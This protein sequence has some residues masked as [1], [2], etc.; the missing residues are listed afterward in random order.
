MSMGEKKLISHNDLPLWANDNE[1]IVSG[2][3]APGGVNE[4]IRLKRRGNHGHAAEKTMKTPRKRKSQSAISAKTINEPE[5]Y[6]H[7][8]FYRCW[9]SIWLYIHNESVNIHTHFWGALVAISA[10]ALHIL[11][12]FDLVPT[13]LRPI[14]HHSLFYS[15]AIVALPRQPIKSSWFPFLATDPAPVSVPV[16]IGTLVYTPALKITPWLLPQHRPNDW[17]DIVG[18]ASFLIGAVTVLTFSA[19]FHTVVC[20][21]KEVSFPRSHK[22]VIMETGEWARGEMEVFFIFSL[23]FFSFTDPSGIEFRSPIFAINSTILE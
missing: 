19:T 11:A 13:T 23:S 6:E 17:K 10:M 14:T 22:L 1:F 4:E 9:R 7:D 8:T 5:L 12:A 3:R 18:F 15:K 2:Y 20:H 21:S 16:R